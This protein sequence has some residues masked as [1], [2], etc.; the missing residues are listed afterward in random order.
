MIRLLRSIASFLFIA[1]ILMIA[2]VG[3]WETDCE[4]AIPATMVDSVSS[5]TAFPGMRFRFK[6]IDTSRIDGVL[7]PANTIGYGYVRE[8]TAA[9]NRDR[10]GSLVLEIREVV[11]KGRHFQVMA[12]PRE[13]AIWAPAATMV[14]R[15][16]DY[17]P[18][19]GMIRTAANEVRDG[20]NV[21]LGPGFKFHVVGLGDPREM[22]PC[23]K[24]GN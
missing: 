22:E 10:N 16:T 5:A 14:E 23:H 8:V 1:C 15:A 11:Y 2:R 6:I 7:I 12:D 3:A 18:I 21:T 13:T 17:L 9:S 24:V 19:P 4:A 20:K